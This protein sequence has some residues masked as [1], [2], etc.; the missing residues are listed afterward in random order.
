MGKISEPEPVNL[1]IGMLSGIPDTFET[2]ETELEKQYGPIDIKSD[3]IQFTRTKYYQAEMGS[4]IMRKFIGFKELIDP[5]TLAS[6][7]IVSN[8]LETQISSNNRYNLERV[9]NIDPGYLCKSRIILASTKDFS[10][11]IYLRD[12]IFAEVT[13][14]YSSKERSYKHLQWTFPDYRT[15]E[16]ISF[17]N[18]VRELYIKKF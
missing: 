2:V 18:R 13:L 9:I 12:G 5:V 15:D 1:V 10:H 14:M 6:I 3:L 4:N 16:Y 17:F 8:E 7:K 11:R